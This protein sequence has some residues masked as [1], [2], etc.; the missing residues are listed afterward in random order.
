[1]RRYI[2]KK[3]V[4]LIS[5][6]KCTYLV[7]AD[8]SCAYCRTLDLGPDQVRHSFRA[9]TL[10]RSGQ[11]RTASGRFGA[12]IAVEND[13]PCKAVGCERYDSEGAKAYIK[14]TPLLT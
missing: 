14:G 12:A 11:Q 9:Y 2:S 10:A 6:G 8:Q 13:R 7:N 4:A 1:M 3:A 5:K